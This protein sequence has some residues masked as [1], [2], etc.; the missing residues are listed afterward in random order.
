MLPDVS[1]RGRSLSCAN[2]ESIRESRCYFIY[3]YIYIPIFLNF[4]IGYYDETVI[5]TSMSR[6]R[7]FKEVLGSN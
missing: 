2:W 3:I 7:T 6:S 4:I 1:V 5:L